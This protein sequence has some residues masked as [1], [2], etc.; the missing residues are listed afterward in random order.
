MEGKVILLRLVVR[1][2]FMECAVPVV[3]VP[4]VN[5]LPFVQ[6]RRRMKGE[7]CEVGDRAG[8]APELRRR[9]LESAWVSPLRRFFRLG[10]GPGAGR[11]A[12]FMSW[13]SCLM[14]PGRNRRGC[15]IMCAGRVPLT[16]PALIVPAR[17]S[18]QLADAR[19]PA[20]WRSC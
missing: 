12:C 16:R 8:N 20:C 18:S 7:V 19:S 11:N 3:L 10:C 6:F 15:G 17:A 5:P 2:G 4:E 14:T 9:P 13:K 1:G